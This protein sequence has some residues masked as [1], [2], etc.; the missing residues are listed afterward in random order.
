V[1]LGKGEKHT[2]KGRSGGKVGSL[3]AGPGR[4][5]RTKTVGGESPKSRSKNKG[6]TP[7][8][9]LQVSVET[10][11]RGRDKGKKS[12]GGKGWRKGLPLRRRIAGPHGKEKRGG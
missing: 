3:K 2:K 1:K 6:G 7:G 9:P 8:L 12:F 4:W 10:T 5:R 11:L